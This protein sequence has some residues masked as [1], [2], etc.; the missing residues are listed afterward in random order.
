MRVGV[1]YAG[2]ARARKW[3]RDPRGFRRRERDVACPRIGRTEPLA[4]S[5]A[6]NGA[7]GRAE[8]SEVRRAE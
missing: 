5:R 8:S 2:R 6:T 1:E 4:V 7:A 3:V